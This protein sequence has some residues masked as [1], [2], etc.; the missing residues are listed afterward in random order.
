MCIRGMDMIYDTK[1]NINCMHLKSA[2]TEEMTYYEDTF[3]EDKKHT[4]VKC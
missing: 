1:D 3:L 2:K 4:V